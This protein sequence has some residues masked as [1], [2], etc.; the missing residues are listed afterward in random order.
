MHTVS[1]TKEI[2]ASPEAVWAVLDDFGGVARYN[3]HVET[4]TVVDGPDTGTGAIRECQF[5]DGGRIEEEIVDYEFASG[6]TVEFVD[7]G[8]LPLKRNV[9]ELTI[10]GVDEN[11]TAVTMTATFTPKFG[12]IGWVMANV[13]MK[14]RFRRTF[15]AVLDGLASHLRTGQRVGEDGVLVAPTSSLTPRV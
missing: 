12:P 1:V 14:S 5:Y 3:P 7:M 2:D 15:E 6:Y 13:M 4:S 9:V 10:L 8:G 11:R